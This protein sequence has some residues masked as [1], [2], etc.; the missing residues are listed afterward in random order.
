MW[1]WCLLLLSAFVPSSF[2]LV[3]GSHWDGGLGVDLVNSLARPGGAMLREQKAKGGG[4]DFL[5]ALGPCGPP[6]EGLVRHSCLTTHASRRW[7]LTC[8][9]RLRGS[10]PHEAGQGAL[11]M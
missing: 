8:P 1:H 5:L 7:N 6:P 11:L 4:G 2:A 10:L 3:L 9:S